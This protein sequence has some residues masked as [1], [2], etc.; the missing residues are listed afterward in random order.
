MIFGAEEATNSTGSKQYSPEV[1]RVGRSIKLP[2]KN[3]DSFEGGAGENV[4]NHKALD[5]L[6][7][8]DKEILPAMNFNLSKSRIS[9]KEKLAA[10]DFKE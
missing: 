7:L 3:G 9:M 10:S 4:T 5:Q 6:G 8:D 2:C 1:S